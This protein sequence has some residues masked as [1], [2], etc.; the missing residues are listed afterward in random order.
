MESKGKR[1]LPSEWKTDGKKVRTEKSTG[2]GS[3]EINSDLDLRS[4]R[5][6]IKTETSKM[7]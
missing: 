6:K 3:M 2:F 7:Q 5:R 4:V 1:E